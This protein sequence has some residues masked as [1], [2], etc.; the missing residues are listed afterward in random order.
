MSL[1]IDANET[2]MID[3]HPCSSTFRAARLMKKFIIS[4]AC[5]AVALS[6]GGSIL[7]FACRAV[8]LSV[9][10]SILSAASAFGGVRHFTFLYEAPTSAPGSF[11][12]ENWVTWSRTSDPARADELTFRHEL[13]IGV[14][15]RFQASIYFVDWSYSHEHGDSDL[16]YSDSALELIYNLT[17]P[18]IDPIG[19]SIYQE[20]KVGDR[21]F[22]WESKL[23]AQKNLGPFILAYN[24]TLEAVWEGDELEEREGEFQQALGA[25][26]EIVPQ[27]SVGLELLHEFV[28]PRWRDEEEIRNFFVGPNV[29]YRRGNWFVTVTALAQATDTTEEPDF[30]M[31]TIFGIGL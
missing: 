22:E 12:L 31:R 16:S 15:D 6:V 30:Q 7:S 11:E 3:S 28:F 24:A 20:F 8:A 25:S 27:L 26:Y 10:G 5:R 29:S 4:F 2:H 14:T 19:L 1:P 17:N 13:E 9:G 18:V 23:I 21:L